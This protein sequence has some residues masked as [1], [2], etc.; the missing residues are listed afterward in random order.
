M[1]NVL[2]SDLDIFPW[3]RAITPT[4]IFAYLSFTAQSPAGD[5]LTDSQ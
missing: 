1:A 4:V 3:W 5:I 2:L